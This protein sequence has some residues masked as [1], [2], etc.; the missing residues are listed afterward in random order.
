LNPKFKP[1][2][3]DRLFYDQW[4]YCVSFRLDEVSA[5]RNSLDPADIADVL[6]SREKWRTRVRE[7]WPHNN[8][9]RGH[10]AITD[11][12]REDL[13]AFADFL[14][15]IEESYKMVISVNQCRVYSNSAILLERMGRLPFVHLPNYTESKII[16]ARNTLTLVNPL[17]EYRSYFRNTKL[18]TDEKNHLMDFLNG[19]KDVR[20]SPGLQQWI[21]QPF[22]RTQN[23]FFIDYNGSSWLTMLSLVRPGL[24]RRTVQIVAK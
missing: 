8:F 3:S 22:N 24:I 4:Q 1:V 15:L 9:V 12:T 13:Y 18:S 23:Y 5:L 17:H 11:R 7:R 19:Q 20:K 6:D 10:D 16:R 2:K 21:D 14:S